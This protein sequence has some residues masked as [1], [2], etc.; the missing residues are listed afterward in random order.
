VAE[1]PSCTPHLLLLRGVGLFLLLVH[2]P[3]FALGKETFRVFVAAAMVERV[4]W[5]GH[6][7]V[8]SQGCRAFSSHTSTDSAMEA[9]C[10]RRSLKREG[11][12]VRR[13]EGGARAIGN[14]AC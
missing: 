10:K 9:W 6:I 2:H 1:G 4:S 13:A 3:S 11:G 8:V 7:G 12:G 14:T 5:A